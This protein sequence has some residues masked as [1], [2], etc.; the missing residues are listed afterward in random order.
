[1]TTIINAKIGESKGLPRVWMEGQ[2]LHHGGVQ[3]G[4]K[5]AIK[6]DV[7]AKR[8]ELIEVPF[9]FT[10]KHLTVSKRE[11]N[12]VIHPVIDLRSG[13]IREVFEDDD[14]VRIALRRGRIVITA[15]QIQTKIRERLKRIKDKLDR[16]EKLPVASLFHGGGVLDRAIHSGMLRAGV[17]SFIQVGVELESEYLDASLRNN[18]QLWTEDSIAISSDVR[19]V[20]LGDNTPEVCILV[21]GIPCVGASRSGKSKNKLKCAEDHDEAGALYIDYLNWVRALNPAIALIENVS[22]YANTASMSAIRKVL[23]HLGYEL[24]ETV[25]NAWDFGA[26]ERRER[27]VLVAITKGLGETFSFDNLKVNNVRESCISN[28]LDPIPLDDDR[29][30]RYEYLAEKEIRDKAAGK[31]FRRQL[32]TGKE[33]G[34]GVI[35]RHY[36]K[37]RSTE[38]FLIHPV[39]PELSRLFTKGEH[40]RIKGIP[41][42]ILNGVSETTAQEMAGQSVGYGQFESVGEEIGGCLLPVRNNILKFPK[43]QQALDKLEDDKH[44]APLVV[45]IGTM[46]LFN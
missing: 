43:P 27:M 12:G 46:S 45:Q 30:K 28:I 37:G 9:D 24:H 38:P 6:A 39:R 16:G 44:S 1:M 25:L 20:Y 31:G 34:C 29:W 40:A 22:D 26:L 5:Y 11:R 3:I 14:K 10:G 17:G 8:L 19:D 23:I 36:F 32:L 33:D 2:K 13:Q 15:L 35:G 41:Q 42:E 18:P 7:T 4:K 21:G